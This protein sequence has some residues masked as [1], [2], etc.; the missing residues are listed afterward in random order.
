ME[1][2][3]RLSAIASSIVYKMRFEACFVLSIWI[4]WAVG[5]WFQRSKANR[6]GQRGR[7]KHAPALLRRH[8]PCDAIAS[9]DASPQNASHRATAGRN[10]RCGE[11]DTARIFRDVSALVKGTADPRCLQ[12]PA[13]FIP[14]FSQLCNSHSH[15]SFQVYQAAL[16]A[17]LD[18]SHVSSASQRE[19]LLSPLLTSAIRSGSIDEVLCVLTDLRRQNLMVSGA[20]FTSMVKLCTSKHFFQECLAIAD[21]VVDH[22]SSVTV[23]KSVWSCLIFC[24]I[25][26]KAYDRCKPLFE[27]LKASGSPSHQDYRNMIRQA[28]FSSD[29]EMMLSLVHEMREQDLAIDCVIYNTA[30][31]ACV[32]A[33]QICI[34]RKLLQEMDVGSVADVITY[35]T[36]MKGYAKAGNMEECHGV[37]ELMWQRGLSPSQVSYGILLDGWLNNNRADKAAEIFDVMT[38]Q[39]CPM[40]TVLYTTLIK[41]FARE[42]KIDEA[43][44]VYSQMTSD[45]SVQPDLITFSILLKANCDV[46]RL[47]DGIEL[48]GAMLKIGLRPDD[49]ILNNLLAGCA[50][51]SNIE[52]ARKLYRDMTSAGIRPSNA[53][54]SILIRLYAEC[55]LLDEALDMLRTES[56]KHDVAL[57]ERIY[58]QLIHCCVRARIGKRAVEVYKAMCKSV[59]PTAAMHAGVLGVCVKLNMFDTAVELLQAAASGGARVNAGDAQMVLQHARRKKKMSSAQACEAIMQSMDLVV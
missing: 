26:T 57:E 3:G 45:G 31:A 15:K 51:Q 42:G 53:T 30:L 52:L 4:L 34:A 41:G 44:R 27:R 50:K 25:E 38:R 10:S 2:F 32:A 40:N 23:D 47:R 46:G 21:L 7:Q 28:S 16:D 20:I 54:F 19:K 1:F 22:L 24:A 9:F 12:N 13:W 48:L 29:W 56:K 11:G 43:M 18:L 5:A 6:I 17:G 58:V 49:V 14:R 37:Y 36:V 33:D 55:G 35:N 8:R 39:A 59:V